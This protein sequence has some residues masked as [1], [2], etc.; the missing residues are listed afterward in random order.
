MS[1]FSGHQCPV[2]VPCQMGA[3]TEGLVAGTS[4]AAH[5]ELGRVR[6][7]ASVGGLEVD[8]S[9]DEIRA[10]CARSN[11]HFVHTI[12]KPF[13]VSRSGWFST[14]AADECGCQ[15]ARKLHWPAPAQPSE[16]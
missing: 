10:V 12:N 6:N 11:G 7:F 8:W 14:L 9:G 5:R 1:M 15:S 2:E 16:R 4:A 13:R 3:V